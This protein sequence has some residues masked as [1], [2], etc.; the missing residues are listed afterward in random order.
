MKN[1]SRKLSNIFTNKKA[2][3][4][5]NK[6]VTCVEILYVYPERIWL[7]EKHSITFHKKYLQLFFQQH[8]LEKVESEERCKGSFII[9]KQKACL[10][11]K[12][13]KGMQITI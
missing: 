1:P 2:L 7:Y 3:F 4:T 6:K 9:K 8:S 5:D 12:E 13:K 11:G 10:S